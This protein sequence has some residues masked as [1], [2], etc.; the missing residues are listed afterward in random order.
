L[1]DQGEKPKEGEKPA[2]FW[3]LP[4]SSELDWDDAN[5]RFCPAGVIVVLS[6][7]RLTLTT[8]TADDAQFEGTFHRAEL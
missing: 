2:R 7:S 4:A 3:T 8:V 5:G 6:T 1:F